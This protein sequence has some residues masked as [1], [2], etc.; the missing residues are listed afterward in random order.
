MASL[1]I[2][3][4]YRS[5]SEQDEWLKRLKDDLL[6]Y[7]C[8]S[9]GYHLLPRDIGVW[10]HAHAGYELRNQ[11]IDELALTL[12]RDGI[13][14]W[15][16]QVDRSG[17]IRSWNRELEPFPDNAGLILGVNTLHR[18]SLPDPWDR[19]DLS[20]SSLSDM[21]CRLPCETCDLFY[22]PVEPYRRRNDWH[23]NRADHDIPPDITI[24]ISGL[25][26]SARQHYTRLILDDPPPAEARRL[27]TLGEQLRRCR[28]KLGLSRLELAGELGVE[29][30][31]LVAAEHGLGRVD[32]VQGLVERV[33]QL[34]ANTLG[35][36]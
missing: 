12:N 7:G 15:L 33:Q 5:H 9:S 25:S 32:A 18:A 30:E 1:S 14:H 28:M 2:F 24:P 19:S 21:P 8:D 35:L 22:G 16:V 6:Q 23:G 13:E 31:M 17:D 27:H 11:F 10:I 4:S 3:I 26:D 20:F 36:H 29:I 34:Q